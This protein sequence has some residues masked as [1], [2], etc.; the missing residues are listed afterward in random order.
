MEQ[1]SLQLIATQDVVAI[2]ETAPAVLDRNKQA[3]EKINTKAQYLINK[4]TELGMSPELDAEMNDFLVKV[5]DAKAAALLRRTNLTQLFDSVKTSFTTIEKAMD[6]KTAGSLVAAI[7]DARN[8]WVRTLAEIERKR[9]QD[10][11]LKKNQAAE[12]TGLTYKTEARIRDH[13]NILLNDH[14]NRMQEQF[15]ATTLHNYAN[16]V[17]LINNASDQYPSG[18][19]YGY[20]PDLSVEVIYNKKEIAL[21]ILENVKQSGM[22]DVLYN[23]WMVAVKQKKEFLLEMLPG[24]HDSLKKAE[25]DRIAAEQAEQERKKQEIIRAQA[26]Q[27]ARDA[28]TAEEAE[29]AKIRV[30]QAEQDRLIA[31]AK[32]KELEQERERSRKE[33]QLRQDEIELQQKREAAERD[34]KA[35]KEIEMRKSAQEAQDLFSHTAATAEPTSEQAGQVRSGFEIT[36]KAQAGWMLILNLWFQHEGGK[37][38]MDKFETKKLGSIKAWCEKHCYKTG[39]QI[40]SPLLEYKPTYTAVSTNK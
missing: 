15:N 19:Y 1:S 9:L 38:P 36:V 37:L 31:E 35:Q 22:F 16:T 21:E 13:F 29:A 40:K 18:H 34:D 30:Q 28:K 23:E 33:A 25:A 8:E 7:Q 20:N 12:I 5:R 6:P 24:K 32:E 17:D 11:M 39:E 4:R 27:A 14:L 2:I 26:E 10:E 3:I